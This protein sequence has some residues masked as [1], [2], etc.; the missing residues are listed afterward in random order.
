VL[1]GSALLRSKCRFALQAKELKRY[2][3]EG[4]MACAK[5]SAAASF[6]SVCGVLKRFKSK[7]INNTQ[8]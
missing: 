5:S 8:C 6:A 2:L 7:Y 4:K 1:Q 3:L